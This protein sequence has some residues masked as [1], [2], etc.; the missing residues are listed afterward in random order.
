[1]HHSQF[2]RRQ[3]GFGGEVVAAARSEETGEGAAGTDVV[4]ADFGAENVVVLN[5]LDCG[6]EAGT[7][8]WVWA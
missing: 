1:M 2:R 6:I 5:H 3:L 4:G 7:S 8:Q